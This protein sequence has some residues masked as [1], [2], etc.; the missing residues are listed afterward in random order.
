MKKTLRTTPQRKERLILVI[1]FAL[2]VF[3]LTF[4]FAYI[5]SLPEVQP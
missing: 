1:E 3:V 4:V 5:A 2:Y